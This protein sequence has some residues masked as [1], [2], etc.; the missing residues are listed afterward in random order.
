MI[1]NITISEAS[2]PSKRLA[3]H[4]EDNPTNQPKGEPKN[5]LLPTKQVLQPSYDHGRYQNMHY[6]MFIPSNEG[7]ESPFA[8]R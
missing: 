3:G 7:E 2:T 1:F 5:V 4:E 6:N 8:S